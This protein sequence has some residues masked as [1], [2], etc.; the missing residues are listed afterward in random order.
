MFTWWF[1]HVSCVIENRGSV[2]LI[3]VWVLSTLPGTKWGLMLSG[4]VDGWSSIGLK[5]QSKDQMTNSRSL[6]PGH[7]STSAEAV[8][9][10]IHV[11]AAGKA[12]IPGPQA[13]TTLY[14]PWVCTTSCIWSTSWERRSCDIHGHWRY[15][16]LTWINSSIFLLPF[17][18][19]EGKVLCLK[20]WLPGSFQKLIF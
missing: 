2:S 3:S 5:S 20:A 15:L 10:N 18:F 19:G 12:H 13:N 11:P 17:Y 4:W 6:C 8:K 1:P 16:P 9:K 14:L 7:K